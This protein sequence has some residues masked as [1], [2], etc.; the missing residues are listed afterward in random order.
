MRLTAVTR[1]G[2]GP[3]DPPKEDACAK[4][5][6]E[7]VRNLSTGWKEVCLSF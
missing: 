5:A 2:D 4:E 6:E 1:L 7:E 3:I